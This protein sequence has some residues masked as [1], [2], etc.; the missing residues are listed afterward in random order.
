MGRGSQQTTFDELEAVVRANHYSLLLQA[1][2]KGSANLAD[3]EDVVH[4]VLV[5]IAEKLSRGWAPERAEECAPERSS[6]PDDAAARSDDLRR[7]VFVAV[8]NEASKRI[9][10]TARRR[11]IVD[12]HQ[13]DLAPAAPTSAEIDAVDIRDALMAANSRVVSRCTYCSEHP[14]Q[15]CRVLSLWGDGVPDLEIA[16]TLLMAQRTVRTRRRRCRKQLR[17]LL[18]GT[19]A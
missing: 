11:Q 5:R 12:E 13:F 3:A 6:D 7:Y 14:S 16:K 10:R 15:V 2:R 17:E 8:A 19:R 9:V 1:R 4:D 18:G